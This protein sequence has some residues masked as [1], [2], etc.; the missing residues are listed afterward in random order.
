M[1]KVDLITVEELCLILQ[2]LP[3]DL[4]VLVSGYENGYEHFHTPYIKTVE[5]HPDNPYY[6][7]E[8]QDAESEAKE[9][10]EALVLQRMHRSD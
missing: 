7:G 5:Y 10:I 6:D 9:T 1:N 2:D 3:P 4:P 8:Y